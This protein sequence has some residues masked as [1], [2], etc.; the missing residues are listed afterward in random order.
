MH[1]VVLVA[2]GVF[3]AAVLGGMSLAAVRALVLWRTFKLLRQ[4]VGEEL[5]R[6]A[7]KVE[8]TSETLTGATVL[9]EE[10]QTAGATLKE[11][12]AT[13]S[14]LTRAVGEAQAPLSR[15]RALWPRK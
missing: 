10:L 6:L 12:L 5:A 3:V 2:L 7:D 1:A 13:A 8:R 14:A 9:G 4:R 15:A 11:T